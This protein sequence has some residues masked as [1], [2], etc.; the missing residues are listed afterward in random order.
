MLGW[1][2]SS[3]FSIAP[4]T[5]ALVRIA[6]SSLLLVDLARRAQVL[7]VFY[8][9]A[10]LY[11]NHR[12]L[13]SPPREY[14]LSFLFALSSELEVSAAFG[15]IALIYL[16][17]LVGW[18]TR[19]MQVLSW[20]SFV[21][22]TVRVDPLAHGADFVLSALLLWT[23]FLPL[24]RRFSLDALLASLREPEEQSCSE[25][26]VRAAARDDSPVL[27][28]AVLAATLQLSVIYYFNAIHKS[29]WTWRTGSAVHYLV[30]Q[31]RVVTQ[32]GLFLREH[33]PIPV[34]RAM[35]YGTL[36]VEGVL[37]LLILSP[38]GRPWTRRY[39]IAL[40]FGLHTSIA[41]LA[42][43]GMLSPVMMTFSLLL[44]DARLWQSLRER[45]QR[46]QRLQA[47]VDESCG[48]SWQLARLLKRLDTYGRL[49]LHALSELAPDTRARTAGASWIVC[50]DTA[51]V[52]REGSFSAC[53]TALPCGWLLRWPARPLDALL[54]GRD[55]ERRLVWSAR[56]GLSGAP[57]SHAMPRAAVGGDPS[58]VRR[59]L[60]RW[61]GGLR[62]ACVIGL[63]AVCRCSS[64]ICRPHGNGAERCALTSVPL[65]DRMSDAM[66]KSSD[67][68]PPPPDT[69]VITRLDEEE[70]AILRRA[71]ATTGQNT[72]A[73]IKAALRLYARTLPSETPIEL[74]ERFGVVGAV[75]GPEHLSDTY[76]SL[77]D[78]SNKHRSRA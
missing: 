49:Q 7:S 63:M 33:A 12:L 3:Y 68:V 74:F 19:W 39:A 6:L 30:H 45:A 77:I 21:S 10:G 1:L 78:Y 42:N 18:H 24:G 76:K 20:L 25:L 75:A 32:L 4:Q 36:L 43:V 48:L 59:M 27:S 58:R 17:L 57:G 71:R 34:F 40:I 51:A 23:A 64:A 46:R 72:S 5:L 67:S 53:V 15:V 2:R 28:W 29:G 22:L 41:L 8:T 65:S 61:I 13:W 35:S 69:R 26:E 11:P 52:V 14:A 50:T 47:H 37:P 54:A 73:I 31:E 70:R 44:V 66:P 9:N 56:L 38:W 16:A 60:R 62:E 55:A